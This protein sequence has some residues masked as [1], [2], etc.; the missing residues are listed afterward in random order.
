MKAQIVIYTSYL[1]IIGG[2]ETFV[3]NFA[4]MFSDEYDIV[5]MTPRVPPDMEVKLS[6]KVRIVR[7]CECEC[8]VLLMMR[9]MDDVPEGV[10]YKKLV[11][12]CH[13]CKTRAEWHIKDYDEVV[14]V[15]EES[16]RSFGTN[17]KV[18]HNLLAKN[19][20][21]SL[22]L[23][24]ATRIPAKDK[25]NHE[26]RMMKLARMLNKEHI[27]FLWLNF[28]N[29][30]LINAPKGFMNVGTF[31]DMQSVIKKADYLVQLSDSEGW[32]Y[33]VLESLIN[34]T[35]VIVTPFPTASEMGIRDG[36]NG[37]VVPFDMNFDVHKLLKVPVFEYEYD[38]EALKKQWRKVLGKGK[39]SS[40]PQNKELIQAKKIFRDT[41]A[42]RCL[43]PNDIYCVTQEKAKVIKDKGLGIEVE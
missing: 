41:E 7:P 29:G 15:S 3:Y 42:D 25:G 26:E 31:E 16:K 32:S 13:G 39:G 35:P 40:Q 6:R 28:S 5:V 17:G 8:D 36:L 9:I 10:K 43:R 24:S 34:Q 38:N 20:N 2:I 23:V 19:E 33:S 1:Y 12:M 21:E 22:L 11:R 18:I 4:D 14:H 30:Q 27:P 37:Y